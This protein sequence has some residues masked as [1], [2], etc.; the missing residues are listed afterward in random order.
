MG[1]FE[2]AVRVIREAQAHIIS[3][4]DALRDLAANNIHGAFDSR[5]GY[6]GYDYT[7]QQWI[8]VYPDGSINH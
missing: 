8:A 7:G 2:R 1:T 5:G 6:T 3:S 4:R